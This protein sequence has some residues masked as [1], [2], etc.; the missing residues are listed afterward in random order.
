ARHPPH[1]RRILHAPRGPRILSR[2]RR[3]PLRAVRGSGRMGGQGHPEHGQLREVLERPYHRR[4]RGRHLARQAVPGVVV[5][6]TVIHETKEPVSI[7]ALAGKP[8]QMAMLMDLARLEQA[9]YERKPDAD[10]PS[11]A[12]ELV[13]AAVSDRT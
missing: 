8:A 4:V 2:G 7:S 3:E 11:Q 13:N 1:A 6:K 9:Y 12:Q 5:E 10:D